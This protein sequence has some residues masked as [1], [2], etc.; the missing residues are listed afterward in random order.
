[1]CYR[2]VLLLVWHTDL[3]EAFG[4]VQETPRPVDFHPPEN[5][6]NRDIPRK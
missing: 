2:F 4:A 1:M 6:V 3:S 5:I